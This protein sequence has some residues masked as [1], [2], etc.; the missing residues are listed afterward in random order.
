MVRKPVL[1]LD[2]VVVLGMAGADHYVADAEG[3]IEA[4]GHAAQH[5]R[6]AVE[7]VEQQGGGDGGIDLARPRFDEH[8]LAARDPGPP[9]AEAADLVR[10]GRLVGE[11]GK[12]FGKG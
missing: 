10:V 5:Q 1:L 3:R 11:V 8:R 7:T 12:L 6:P 4:A 2:A 9:E